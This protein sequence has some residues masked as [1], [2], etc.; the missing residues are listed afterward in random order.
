MDAQQ[1]SDDGTLEPG[2]MPGVQG[3]CVIDWSSELRCHSRWLRTVLVAR[4]RDPASIDELLQ[5]VALCAI[6]DGDSVRD[7]SRVAPWLYRVAVRQALLRRR[8][9]GRQR[10]LRESLVERLDEVAVS[11]VDDLDPLAWL[12]ADERTRQVRQSL[13]SLPPREAEVLL[14]K[15]SE[16]WSYRQIAEHLGLTES[17][18]DARLHRARRRL[19]RELIQRNVVEVNS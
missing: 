6:R 2:T 18:V 15:Y 11:G 13:D 10:R 19:R 17:A 5:E 4:S 16:D 14:L 1:H 7:T 3:D 9:L 12:I 8:R